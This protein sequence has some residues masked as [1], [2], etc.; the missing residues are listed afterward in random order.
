VSACTTTKSRVERQR[1]QVNQSKTDEPHVH[2]I[3]TCEVKSALGAPIIFVH[4]P[5][6]G[7]TTLNRLIEWEYSP[8]RVMFD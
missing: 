1:V 4:L 2:A 8:T 7:G 3:E 5:K 6:C